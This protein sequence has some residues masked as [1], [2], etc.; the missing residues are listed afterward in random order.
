MTTTLTV[1]DIAII[2]YGS[3]GN[4]TF[5]FVLLEDIDA[6]TV[7][8]FT[9]KGYDA[10][11]DLFVS[12][13]GTLE[14]TAGEDLAAGTVITISSDGGFNATNSTTGET[15]GT[16]TSTGDFDL[17]ANGDSLFAYQ[18]D[19]TADN[20]IYGVN[21]GENPLTNLLG[22]DGW[23][24]LSILGDQGLSNL[25]SILDFSLNGG[26]NAAL[27]LPLASGMAIMTVS[28]TA[29]PNKFSTRFL[30]L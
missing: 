9:D 25:P 18:G 14:W 26:I 20:L 19:L 15:S 4:D 1:G 7:I 23:N 12:L 17:S 29:H 28:L 22:L 24:P 16:V 10:F 3:D 11:L 2:Q 13:E 6:E 30:T 27:G 8:K 5:S 21:F